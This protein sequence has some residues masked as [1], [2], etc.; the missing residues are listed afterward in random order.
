[1]FKLCWEFVFPDSV[2][3]LKRDRVQKR[4]IAR[5]NKWDKVELIRI[6]HAETLGLKPEQ[7]QLQTRRVALNAFSTK[8]AAARFQNAEIH[9]CAQLDKPKLAFASALPTDLK[10]TSPDGRT[11]IFGT[12]VWDISKRVKRFDLIEKSSKRPSRE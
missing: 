3:R 1:M 5:E 7:V 10:S 8:S 11:A 6:G 12:E 9:F 2:A 4:S